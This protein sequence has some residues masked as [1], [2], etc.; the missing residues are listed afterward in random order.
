MLLH[1]IVFQTQVQ[2]QGRWSKNKNSF[3]CNSGEN[4]RCT[5]GRE[6]NLTIIKTQK[7]PTL[8]G[9]SPLWDVQKPN[10]IF[11]S[12]NVAT[13]GTRGQTLMR[14]KVHRQRK[15]LIS[16]KVLYHYAGK[17][18]IQR[19]CSCAAASYNHI[20]RLTTGAPCHQWRLRLAPSL[21][22]K[23]QNRENTNMQEP[24]INPNP[25]SWRCQPG[26]H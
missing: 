3:G 26:K 4:K 14:N 6:K 16:A 18:T 1:I 10:L 23:N 11:V 15:L 19:W 17:L 2:I 25:I 9:D 8:N 22:D 21:V 24:Y 13:L 7:L 20:V 5:K 12:G